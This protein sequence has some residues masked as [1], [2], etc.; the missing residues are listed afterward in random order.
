MQL[1]IQLKSNRGK[2]LRCL[3]KRR[4][5]KVVDKRVA[6]SVASLVIHK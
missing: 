6:G 4:N 3:S 1:V 2:C 5:A